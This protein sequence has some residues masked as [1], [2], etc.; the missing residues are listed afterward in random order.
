MLSF[1]RT[2]WLRMG[3]DVSTLNIVN[4]FLHIVSYFLH[5]VSYFQH[6]VSYFL[7][8]VSKTNP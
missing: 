2:E 1:I 7:H 4:Y 8:I 3:S 6:I 5:I